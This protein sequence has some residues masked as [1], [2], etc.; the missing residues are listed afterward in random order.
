MAESFEDG[1]AHIE[2]Y[3]RG[4][5][6]ALS[7]GGEQRGAYC[8]R[9]ESPTDVVGRR[10]RD[11]Q[12]QRACEYEAVPLGTGGSLTAVLVLRDGHPF[13]PFFI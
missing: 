13:F 1:G 2:I 5:V 10:G 4:R 8:S 12:K 6:V 3:A 11:L 7:S 9:M